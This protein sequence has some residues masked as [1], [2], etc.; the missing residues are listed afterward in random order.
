[1][2]PFGEVLKWN[3]QLRHVKLSL[4]TVNYVLT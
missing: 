1:M 4:V 3:N 2:V